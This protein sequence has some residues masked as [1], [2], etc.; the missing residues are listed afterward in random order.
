VRYAIK[1]RQTL[2]SSGSHAVQSLL[3]RDFLF[4]ASFLH[5]FLRHK[6]TVPTNIDAFSPP[7]GAFEPGSA[8]QRT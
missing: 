4:S 7:V 1:P 6:R 3:D 5:V 2:H 8:N